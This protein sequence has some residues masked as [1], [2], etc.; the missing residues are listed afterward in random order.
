MGDSFSPDLHTGTGSLKVPIA[1]PP[2]RNG[3]Q[4]DL[5]L[6]YSTGHGNGPFGLGWSLS[7]PGIA[8]DTSRGVPRY[9]DG[10]DIFLLSGAERLVAT[11]PGPGGAQLYRPR[12]EGMFARIQHRLSGTEDYWE[13]RNRSGLRSLYGTPGSGLTD[14]ATIR[15]PDDRSRIFSWSL[16]QTTDPFGNRIDYLYERDPT[17]EDGPHRWD[18]I[19]LKTIRYADWGPR[20]APQFLVSVTFL[21][22]ARPDPF[23]S[24]RAGFEIRTTQRCSGIEIRTHAETELLTRVYRFRYQDELDDAATALPNNGASLLRR[25]ETEGV[26]GDKREALPP[27]DFA[28]SGFDP[29]KRIYRA[30]AGVGDS[31]PERSL[32]HPDFELADLFGRGLPDVVQ[33][34]DVSRYWRNLGGGRFDI[35]RPLD[36]LPAGIRLGDEGTQLADFDGDGQVDLLISQ[37]GLE[38]YVPLTAGPSQTPRPFVTYE[39]APPF[40]F[41]DPELRLLDLDGDGITDALRTG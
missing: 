5:S 1:L 18:Q 2:G 31:I 41:D 6:V 4:P 38:G 32:A 35:P 21:Y 27:L 37:A 28:Y 25:V 7:V 17:A 15:H 16:T 23:S 12:T 26:D 8:R 22:E 9:R 39:A 40:A 10:D 13:V 33:I 3:L 30:L 11:K 36:R 19:R 20:E 34:G 29:S 14:P 24:Y